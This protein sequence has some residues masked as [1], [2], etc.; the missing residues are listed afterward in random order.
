VLVCCALGYS[1]SAA[2]VTAWL[3]TTRRASSV[4]DA[5]S[6]VRKARPAIV[7]KTEH[8]AALEAFA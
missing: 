5:M 1:R 4:E 8:R 6:I 3:L 7:L 2:A